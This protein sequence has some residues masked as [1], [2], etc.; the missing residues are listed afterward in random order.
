VALLP[1]VVLAHVEQDDLAAPQPLRE[2]GHV[3]R[4]RRPDLEAGRPPRTDPAGEVA[5]EA[6]K[7]HRFEQP[8]EEDRFL[9]GRSGDEDL[10]LRG[11][12][13]RGARTDR[14]A[15]HRHVDRPGH[16][17]PV[18]LARVAAVDQD[19]P[20]R[21]QLGDA[22]GRARL[23][24]RGLRQERPAVQLDDP[25]EVRRLRREVR[26]Q[27]ADE[28]ALVDDLQQAVEA[29]LEADRRPGLL[30]HPRATAE[31]AA[32]VPGPGLREVVEL[33]QPPD[34]AEELARALL[35]LDGQVGPRDVADEERVA[36]EDEPRLAGAARVLHEVGEVL[37]AVARRREG[38]DLDVADPHHVCVPQRL[39]LVLDVRLRRDVDGRAG[40]GRE[41]PVARDVVGVVVRL[42][43][44]GD[45][46]VVLVCEREVV[47][48]LPLR[49]DHGRLAAARDDVRGAAEVL[50][51]HLPE[52]H[53]RG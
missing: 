2:L 50:V 15:H 23:Q 18:E 47:R 16:V 52:E 44:V 42:E 30:A 17:R 49:V 14:S 41:A 7:T 3:D 27:L 36:G 10:A 8:R 21:E 51:E 37:G 32:D 25:L 53:P 40:R 5:G 13:P 34:G 26:C 4:L 48:D 38:P 28:G 43:H 6:A 45:P 22:R 1:L 12:H 9:V 11:D 31:R 24:G 29:P 35:L 46:E 39:V 19:R 33:E 20:R